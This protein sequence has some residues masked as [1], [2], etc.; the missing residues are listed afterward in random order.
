MTYHLTSTTDAGPLTETLRNTCT[1]LGTSAANCRAT[2]AVTVAQESTTQLSTFAVTEVARLGYAQI[3]ITVGSAAA[4]R[5]VSNC[6]ANGGRTS[7][8]PQTTSQTASS[9][10]PDGTG[11]ASAV[12]HPP[13]GLSTGAKAGIGVGVG[14]GG[15]ALLVAGGVFLY[16]RRKRR[17]SAPPYQPP[18][19]TAPDLD[20]PQTKSSQQSPYEFEQPAIKHGMPVGRQ[21]QE[22]PGQYGTYELPTN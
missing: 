1:L 20:Q 7:T 15:V 2:V 5:S 11:Y 10:P 12:V 13:S 17:H 22:W 8:S 14:L 19:A 6:S 18:M 21:V 4:L 3:P 16:W 9:D